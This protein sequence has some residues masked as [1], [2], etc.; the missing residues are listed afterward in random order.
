ME[1]VVV[2]PGICLKELRITTKNLRIVGIPAEIR[3]KH[4]SDTSLHHYRYAN[5]LSKLAHY[6]VSVTTVSSC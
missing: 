5:P 1:A 2:Y 4:F 3:P 6:V